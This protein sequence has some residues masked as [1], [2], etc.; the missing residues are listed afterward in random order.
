MSDVASLLRSTVVL[1]DRREIWEWAHERIDFG[2]SEAFKGAYDVDNV[3]WTR[4]FLRA[5]KDPNVREVTFV[6]PPQE[7]GKTKAS[8]VFMGWRI[9]NA[10]AK[11]A[12]NT[13]TNVKAE[14]WSETRWDGLLESCP[15]VKPKFSSNRHLKKKRRIIF[16]DRTFLLIQ[17]A[18][19]DGNRA[20]DSVE[21]Q[22][23]DEVYLWETPW[24]REMN[25]RTDAYRE[26]RK[27]LNIS[28]GGK[29]GSELQ[30][31][32][33][34][35]NQGEWNHRCPKCKKP[36]AY[37]FDNKKPACNIRFN[38]DAA[39]VHADGRVDLREFAKTVLVNCPDPACG[40]K[41]GYDRDQMFELNRS[42]LYVPMNPDA[43]PEIV[44]LH[45]NS[46]AIGRQPWHEILEPWV[47]LHVRGGVFA[48]EVLKEFITKPLAEFWDEQPFVVPTE[49]ALANFKRADILVRG[50]WPEEFLRVMTADNQHGR[51][52]D[53][54][55]R[56][57][58]GVA[59]SRAGKLRILDGGRL[60]EWPDLKKKQVELG[61]PDPTEQAPG[62]WVAVDRRYD[63]VEVDEVCSRYKWTGFMGADQ[64]EF[65]HP[66]YSPFAGTRQLFT[67][68]RAIDVG[69]GTAEMGRRFAIYHFW[70]T[71]R[72]QDLLAKLR[73]GGML[74]VPRDI[75]EWCPD[76][77]EHLG[78]HR[79]I[80]EPLRNG[81]DRLV[82]K[83]IGSAPDHL[84][85]CLCEAVV[86]GCM[87]GIY[88]LE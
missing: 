49:L 20:S 57:F 1:P 66:P 17:G 10:P 29:K 2:N 22:V 9:C 50:S 76:F 81:G 85:D 21:V 86:I 58:L 42:G 45:V 53:V 33:L 36:F 48:P 59:F 16:R 8:E 19:T 24:L 71:Q 80:K 35:G 4:E 43:N 51:A 12:F 69:F 62:P 56:W 13:S 18:E 34:A 77:A 39:I 61:I 30:Q 84:Y 67:E 46:F 82:W 6:A 15:D 11:M 64:D 14:Q 72:V 44:S 5:A 25:G 37:V 27:I 63:P 23:N 41:T 38:L 65:V 78:S 70:A 73:K 75:G 31:K 47:R 83:R 88:R 28:V 68:P 60:N 26:V 40:W 7:S 3:P 55:H 32:F 54:P 52:G 87:A 74:E 79:Q